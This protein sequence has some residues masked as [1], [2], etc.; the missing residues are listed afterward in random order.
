MYY[1][2]YYVYRL[3]NTPSIVNGEGG[4]VHKFPKQCSSTVTS[5]GLYESKV[6][7]FPT[8]ASS[9]N[10]S[11]A[12]FMTPCYLILP[13]S[14]YPC[15]HP[16]SITRP[17]CTPRHLQ[18]PPKSHPTINCDTTFVR[19]STSS[20]FISKLSACL[21][22]KA[23]PTHGQCTF[24]FD[25]N[26][27][28]SKEKLIFLFLFFFKYVIRYYFNHSNLYRQSH[29]VSLHQVLGA[30]PSRVWFHGPTA[31]NSVDWLIYLVCVV[32]LYICSV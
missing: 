6:E 29:H 12:I 4:W 22:D 30:N 20:I 1:L 23:T 18:T 14:L 11:K 9:A 32:K 17:L 7:S 16:S 10:Y 31:Y 2:S 28:Q 5:I 21:G 26:R 15:R 19:N 3:A 27:Q 8:S 24:L 13:C 25:T